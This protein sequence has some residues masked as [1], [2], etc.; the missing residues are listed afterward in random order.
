MSATH[1]LTG[2]CQPRRFGTG[3]SPALGK[4]TQIDGTAFAWLAE[5]APLQGGKKKIL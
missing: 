4:P 2:S 3:L 1:Q 5:Q